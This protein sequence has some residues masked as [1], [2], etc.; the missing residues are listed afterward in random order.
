MEAGQ[1]PFDLEAWMEAALRLG[2]PQKA[3]EQA[4]QM[5]RA[6]STLPTGAGV[7]LGIALLMEGQIDQAKGAFAEA[8]QRLQ[9]SWPPR[10]A[11]PAERWSLLCTLVDDETLRQEV[12]T[13]FEH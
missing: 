5:L 11:I 4:Q 13:Y 7:L 6:T 8:V 10:H 12:G 2:E 3:S 1:A 9:R